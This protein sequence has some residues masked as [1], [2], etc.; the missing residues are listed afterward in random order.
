VGGESIANGVT[1]TLNLDAAI[2]PRMLALCYYTGLNVYLSALWRHPFTLS[3]FQLDVFEWQPR[4][5]DD[6][7]KSADE[8]GPV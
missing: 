7:E 1:V 5:R 8:E 3:T 4:C 2:S 6:K